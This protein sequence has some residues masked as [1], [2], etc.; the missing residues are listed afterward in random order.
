MFSTWMDTNQLS[1]WSEGLK[2]IQA[3]KIREYH[4]LIKYLP[5]EAM[6]GNEMSAIPKDMIGLLR[7]EEN[8]EN[9]LHLQK[10][11]ESNIRCLHKRKWRFV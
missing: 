4:E 9:R 2:F 1:K 11:T 6:F 7:S 3:M 5:Y 10:N 8:L